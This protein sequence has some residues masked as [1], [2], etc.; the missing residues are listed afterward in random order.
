MSGGS[1]PRPAPPPSSSPAPPPSPPPGRDLSIDAA[2]ILSL[3]LVVLIHLL[4]IGASSGPGGVALS[5]PLEAQPWFAAA[6][7]AGQIM[8]LFFILGGYTGI[9]SWRS[10]SRAGLG[11][12]DHV[13]GRTARLARPALPFF[14]LWLLVLAGGRLAGIDPAL[15]GAV[16]AGAGTPLWFLAAFLLAQS[17]VPLLARLHER[18]RWA[19]PV[20]LLAGAVAVD[21][22]RAV[23]GVEAVGWLNFA[24]VWCFAQQLGF[25]L[26]DGSL[27]RLR[28]RPGGAAALLGIAALGYLLLWPGVAAGWHSP[29]MLDNLNP[30]TV[31]LALLG[32]AQLALFELARPAL[33][34]L[35]RVRAAQ[36]AAFVVGSR[37]MTVYLWHLPVIIALTGLGLLLPGGGPAPDSPLWWATRPLAYALVLACVLLLAVPL[38]RFERLPEGFGERRTSPAP[39][40]LA[41]VLA[42]AAAFWVTVSGLGLANAAAGTAALALSWA[43]VRGRP[44]GQPSGAE[45]RIAAQRSG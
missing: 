5:R 10:A 29:N 44:G 17:A 1:A 45:S 22:A 11:W 42:F 4:M 34:R 27:S 16:A 6:T 40:V 38:A 26:L 18:S 19:A 9:R 7:W 39:A 13:R 36:A 12:W 37:S 21:A 43:L 24:L 23:T 25:F 41:A 8:P 30:P 33:R 3:L 14:A 20:A 32:L 35:M 28:A 2:R 31:S 15:L